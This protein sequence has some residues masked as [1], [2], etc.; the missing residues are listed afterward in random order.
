METFVIFDGEKKA[1]RFDNYTVFKMLSE[2]VEFGT[3]FMGHA[4]NETEFCR[5]WAFVL[6]VE[7]D[8]DSKT[9][10]NNFSNFSKLNEVVSIAL[11]RD[12]IISLDPDSG[13]KKNEK[14]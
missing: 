11:Q 2:G 3:L 9:F 14:S 13:A 5:A 8:G 12:G 6:G 10:M 1:V 4:A 7:F